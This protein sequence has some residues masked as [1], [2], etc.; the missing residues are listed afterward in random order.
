M[1]NLFTPYNLIGAGKVK[2]RRAGSSDPLL[3]VGNVLALATD[4]QVRDVTVP[5]RRGGGGNAFSKKFLEA[6]NI[7]IT[8]ANMDPANIARVM[9]GDATEQL[10]SAP[11]A[12]PHAAS[13]G[14]FILLGLLDDSVAVLVQDDTDTTTYVAGTD[15]DL[16][17]TGITPLAGG[18]ITEA[19]VLHISYGLAAGDVIELFTNSG[20]EWEVVLDG[21]NDADGSNYLAHFYRWTVS[22]AGFEI[23]GEDAAQMESSGEAL[24]DTSKGSGVSKFGQIKIVKPV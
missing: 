20:E 17:N 9:G 13:L 3:D 18:A 14:G 7:N 5:N 1:A 10:A 12:D 6:L 15:Y 22:P 19:D 8:F 11:S 24:P 4:P 21:V 2:M 16:S 23:L